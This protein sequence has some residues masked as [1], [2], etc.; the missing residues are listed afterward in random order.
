MQNEIFNFDELK[1]KFE[2]TLADES[3]DHVSSIHEKTR[4]QKSRETVSFGL[5][6]PRI[7][8]EK[9]EQILCHAEVKWF[10]EG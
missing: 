8:L 10:S 4:D 5:R 3:G 9:F 7:F 2:T 6:G 1:L